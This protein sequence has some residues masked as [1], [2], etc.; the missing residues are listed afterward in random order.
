MDVLR[1]NQGEMQRA[2]DET[3]GHFYTLADAD[4]LLHDLPAGTRL[5]LNTPQPPTLLWNHWAMFALVMLLL[6]TEWCLRKWRH[7]V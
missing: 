5:A 3:Q 6:G 4:R 7:L 1:M 2:A